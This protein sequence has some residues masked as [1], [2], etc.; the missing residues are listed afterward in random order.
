MRGPHS[1]ATKAKMRAAQSSVVHAKRWTLPETAIVERLLHTDATTRSIAR[2]YGC[3]GSTIKVIFRAHTSADQRLQARRRKQGETL[4]RIGGGNPEIWK[5]SKWQGRKHTT[6]TRE[7]QSLRKKGIRHSLDRRVAQSARIQGV[8][9][10]KW[11]GFAITENIRVRKGSQLKA[12]RQSVFVRDN[13]TCLMCG[14][15]GGILHAHH[16]RE[17][18]TYP[19]L[20]FEVSNG[21]TLCAEPCHKKTIGR[22]SEYYQFFSHLI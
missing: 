22:E 6:A 3:S 19:E 17:F 2:E 18:A 10:E 20:R 11:Q 4:K 14:K 1:E 8:A 16:I 13:Y 15:R 5:H 7:R 12:W 21:A 9:I